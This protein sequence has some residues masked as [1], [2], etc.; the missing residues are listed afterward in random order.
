MYNGSG[1]K[2]S[3]K[4]DVIKNLPVQQQLYYGLYIS[5]WGFFLDDLWTNGTT[6]QHFIKNDGVLI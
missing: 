5:F 2:Y 4:S 3:A 6:V 1:G